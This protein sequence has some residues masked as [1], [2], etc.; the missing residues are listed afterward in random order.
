MA[1]QYGIWTWWLVELDALNLSPKPVFVFLGAR[2]AFLAGT[3]PECKDL[4]CA[5]P[6]GPLTC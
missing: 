5:E 1:E 2:A 6:T 4:D 3:R